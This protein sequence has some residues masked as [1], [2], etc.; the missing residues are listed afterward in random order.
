MVKQLKTRHNKTSASVAERILLHVLIFGSISIKYFNVIVTDIFLNVIIN[1]IRL[2]SKISSKCSKR[3]AN[4]NWETVQIPTVFYLFMTR[5]CCQQLKI[6]KLC[7]TFIIITFL[8]KE[9]CFIIVLELAFSHVFQQGDYKAEA[10]IFDEAGVE[11]GCYFVHASTAPI[12]CTG[13]ACVIGR[14]RVLQTNWN[15]PYIT[16]K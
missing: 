4:T 14:R 6:C 8:K 13:A 5:K 3:F 10:R 15:C 7:K 2:C 9:T 1:S 12:G 11:V 16:C